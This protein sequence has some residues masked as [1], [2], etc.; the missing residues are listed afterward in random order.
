M[1]KSPYTVIKHRH[2]TEKARVLEGL[3]YASSNPS[4]RKCQSPKYVFIVDRKASKPEIA[5]AVEEIYAEKKI[6]VVAVNTVNV[7]PKNRRIRGRAGATASFK[8]AIVTL[9]PGDSIEN[10]V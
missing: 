3:Q 9:E 4:V 10:Q 7:K 5:A 1:K 6:K 2:V 8:K